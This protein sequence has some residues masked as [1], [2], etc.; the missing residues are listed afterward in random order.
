MTPQD[1]YSDNSQYKDVQV[2]KKRIVEIIIPTIFFFF[3]FFALVHFLYH[4]YFV[5]EFDDVELFLCYAVLSIP[6]VFFLCTRSNCSLFSFATLIRKV[7]H[8]CKIYIMSCLFSLMN[9]F[10]QG[11]ATMRWSCCNLAKLILASSNYSFLLSSLP[12]L[13]F[14]YGNKGCGVFKWG[15]QNQK[16]FC[17]RINIPK[18][19]GDPYQ[20]MKSQ[21]LGGIHSFLIF[22]F[23][24]PY[25]MKKI[26]V[27]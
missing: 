5:S 8:F 11:Q 25:E 21:I 9:L 20:E 26:K 6:I 4:N 2:R 18:G 24:P 12:L 15:V 22:F 1:H 19:K 17:L 16:E 13:I 3:H 10:F 7:Q 14:Q 27:V 23:G